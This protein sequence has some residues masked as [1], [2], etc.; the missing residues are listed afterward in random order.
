[1]RLGQPLLGNLKLAGGLGN[2]RR[3]PDPLLEVKNIYAGGQEAEQQHNR[4]RRRQTT[5]VG[6]GCRYQK[7]N[8]ASYFKCLLRMQSSSQTL[9]CGLRHPGMQLSLGFRRR[10]IKN[11]DKY[12]RRCIVVV[13]RYGYE[14]ADPE[15]AER[16]T[17]ETF[18]SAQKTCG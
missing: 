1:M 14:V 18:P 9:R 11:M 5:E 7:P 16:K 12:A 6:T 2:L 3:L 4:C 17:L 8:S 13:I 15:H 10:Q